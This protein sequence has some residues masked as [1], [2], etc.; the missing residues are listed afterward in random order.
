MTCIVLVLKHRIRVWIVIFG[1]I[2]RD[3]N[4]VI[5][6]GMES[7]VATVIAIVPWPVKA[8][9][10]RVVILTPSVPT[11]DRAKIPVRI[12]VAVVILNAPELDSANTP[13]TT[14]VGVMDRVPAPARVR[15]TWYPTRGTITR[16][17]MLDS[18]STALCANSAVMFNELAPENGRVV[19]PPPV[20]VMVQV[21]VPDIGTT[22]EMTLIPSTVRDPDPAIRP[23]GR[24]VPD[25]TTVKVLVPDITGAAVAPPTLEMT[26]ELV[27]VRFSTPPNV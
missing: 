20:A 11:P 22:P 27:P 21:P 24:T 18:V 12:T 14:R 16:D 19:V 25:A 13:G 7:A 17:P 23:E 10:P 15:E 9:T 1:E 5:G 8:S 6:T 2:S 4:P 3:P 26:K